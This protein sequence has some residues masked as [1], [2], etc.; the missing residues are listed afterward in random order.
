MKPARSVSDQTQPTLQLKKSDDLEEAS[1]AL[2]GASF[3]ITG[4]FENITRE[5]LE[6]FVAKH[7]AKC[8]KQVTPSTEYILVG[9]LLDDGRPVTDGKKYQRAVE[10]GTK[11]MTE[12]EFEHFCRHRFN[13]PD[14]LL[15]RK[16]VKDATEGAYDYFAGE[17]KVDDCLSKVDDI[18]DLLTDLGDA[19]VLPIKR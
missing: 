8:H 13:N 17:T 7:G 16:R 1:G 6:A 4:V 11:V 19:K 3:V 12:R 2:G 15:G 18:S 9:K 10:L 14:F 5:K